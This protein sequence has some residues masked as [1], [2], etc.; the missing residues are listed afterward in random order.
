MFPYWIKY[1]GP[2]WHVNPHGERFRGEEYLQTETH[3]LFILTFQP[4]QSKFSRYIVGVPDERYVA[5]S[6][7]GYC[8][9]SANGS[10][11]EDL[12]WLRKNDGFLGD[13][14]LTRLQRSPPRGG[15]AR[16]A[17]DQ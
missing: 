5:R 14:F 15:G 17:V 10:T 16:L 3:V 6:I 7:P 9:F 1:H 4:S 8:P 11:F 12:G 13:G 2:C